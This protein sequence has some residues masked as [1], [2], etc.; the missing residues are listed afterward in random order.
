MT[1]T[2]YGFIK[3]EREQ[4]GPPPGPIE[5]APVPVDMWVRAPKTTQKTSKATAFHSSRSRS[6]C[7]W[8]S[9]AHWRGGYCS[10]R[11]ARPLTGRSLPM[12]NVSRQACGWRVRCQFCDGRSETRQKS[13]SKIQIKSSLL[14]SKDVLYWS[15]SKCGVWRKVNGCSWTLHTV[16]YTWAKKVSR[17]DLGHIYFKN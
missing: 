3:E 7:H 16:K 14:D 6:A 1:Q 8:D 11:P 12:W 4:N 15:E 9:A 13:N 17:T 5:R 2:N 10:N